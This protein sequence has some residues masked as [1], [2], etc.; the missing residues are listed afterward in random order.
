MIDQ[1]A[2]VSGPKRA[3]DL[4]EMTDV[5]AKLGFS[6]G[7]VRRMMARGELPKPKKLGN[8]LVWSRSTFDKW[9]ADKFETGRAA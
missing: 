5:C 3:P 9:F 2:T 4:I 1:N 7:G 8:R 6:K